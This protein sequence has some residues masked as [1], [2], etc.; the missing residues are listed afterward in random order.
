MKHSN[1]NTYIIHTDSIFPQLGSVY[2]DN[3]L[4]ILCL[5]TWAV[6]NTGIGKRTNRLAKNMSC[7]K[8]HLHYAKTEG[9]QAQALHSPPQNRSKA[10]GWRCPWLLCFFASL[11]QTCLLRRRAGLFF[12]DTRVFFPLPQPW[13]LVLMSHSPEAPLACAAGSFPLRSNSPCARRR[14]PKA[15]SLR[16]IFFPLP[17][18][19][20]WLPCLAHSPAFYALADPLHLQSWSFLQY[21]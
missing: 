4:F 1:I 8:M 15:S 5:L 16:E 12:Q 6:I 7:S 11:L 13:L 19:L 14:Q 17:T 21:S 3:V 10:I 20:Q 9:R 2:N 18:L